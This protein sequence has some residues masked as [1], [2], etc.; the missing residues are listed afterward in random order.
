MI[1][2]QRAPLFSPSGS[3]ASRRGVI[4]SLLAG[5]VA[6]GDEPL[7]ARRREGR[8]HARRKDDRHRPVDDDVHEE[9]KK[10]KKKKKKGNKK[11]TSTTQ[12]PTTAP[13]TTQP[14]TT[15]PPTTQPPASAFVFDQVLGSLVDDRPELLDEP[16]EVATDSSG[17]LYVLNGMQNRIAKY[18]AS[19]SYIRS[20]GSLDERGSAKG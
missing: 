17:N 15:Q 6:A 11:S 20:F 13:P 7:D 8:K 16:G 4:A 5:L 10:K 2:N 12:S 3:G 14:P 9:K 19:G 18:N 1:D